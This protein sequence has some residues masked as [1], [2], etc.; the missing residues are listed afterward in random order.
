MA[1]D[2]H[3]SLLAILMTE[4]GYAGYEADDIMKQL[5]ESGRYQKDVW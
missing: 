4:G 2:V 5:S 3:R 1:R